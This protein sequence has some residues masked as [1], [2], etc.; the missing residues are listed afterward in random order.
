MSLP[1]EETYCKSLLPEG[2]SR[3][4]GTAYFMKRSGDQRISVGTAK[5]LALLGQ[6]SLRIGLE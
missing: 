3:Q 4:L 5:A 1:A 2:T 6:P